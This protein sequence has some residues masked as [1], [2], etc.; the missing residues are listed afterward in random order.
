M[1]IMVKFELKTQDSKTTDI[2]EFFSRILQGTRDFDGNFGAEVSR[3][4]EDKTKLV[5]I[6]YWNSQE[7]F[8]KYLNWRKEIGDFDELGG[9][10]STNP[11]I[12]SFEL[13]DT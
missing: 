2:D 11:D 1:S 3:S 7:D 5:L 10:L 13:L 12:Q 6:E 8:N 4:S 9:M